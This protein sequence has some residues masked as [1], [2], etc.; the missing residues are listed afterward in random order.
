MPEL[1]EAEYMVRRLQLDASGVTIERVRVLRQSATGSQRPSRL[2]RLATGQRIRAFGRRAKSV[3]LHLENAHTVRVQLGMTGHIYRVAGDEPPHT[4]VAFDLA[5]GGTIA[6]DDPR[7]FG[8][9]TIHADADL[10]TVF[11]D[12][13][14]E[15]LDSAFSVKHLIESLS[16]S[17][18][19]IK[20]LLLDQSRVVGLGNIWAAEA[21]WR[22]RVDPFQPASSLSPAQWRKL[23][24]AIVAVLTK[25]VDDTFKVT[26][27]SA[28]FPEADLLSAAVY[29][30]SGQPC[31]RCKGAIAK[32]TQA[33]RSTFYCPV[34]QAR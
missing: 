26:S 2:K 4:R 17:R 21:L 19:P 16:Q 11:G 13:G 25:A 20:P 6:F 34:C 30:R 10:P 33:G 31:R 32:V 15:P 24:Q 8:K 27:H 7:T 29:G 3:L 1:P 28:E 9:V 5:E 18:A 22:S 12:L 14:H 23:H